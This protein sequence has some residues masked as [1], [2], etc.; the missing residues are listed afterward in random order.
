MAAL[1]I[2]DVFHRR[3]MG[4]ANFD[5]VWMRTDST[6]QGIPRFWDVLR[7]DL[8]QDQA[9]TLCRRRRWADVLLKI[10]NHLA[11][12]DRFRFPTQ[13][14]FGGDLTPT[15]NGTNAETAGELLGNFLTTADTMSVIIGATGLAQA[16]ILE[17]DALLSLYYGAQRTEQVRHHFGLLPEAAVANAPNF[18]DVV[19]LDALVENFAREEDESAGAGDEA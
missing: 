3:V 9:N 16:A 2:T 17:D 19:D 7:R 11:H 18:N 10:L 15:L 8:R 4:D 5:R 1:R 12:S 13:F 6:G 14:V